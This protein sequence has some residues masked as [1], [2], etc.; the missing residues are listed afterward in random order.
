MMLEDHIA[1]VNSQL[2]Y[3]EGQIERFPPDNPRYRPA[4][5]DMYRRLYERHMGLLKYLEAQRAR[6]IQPSPTPQST[7]TES[8]V[9]PTPESTG[10]DED[11]SDL[12]P[13]LLAQLSGRAKKGSSDPLVQIINDRGGTAALDE[14]LIDLYRRT[15]EIGVRN[16]ISNK[17]YRLTK[18]GF[19]RAIEGKRG[20]YT[21][22]EQESPD[23]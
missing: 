7:P 19:V 17:L 20:V 8:S 12:P 18:Q 10:D 5:I 9:A 21:T 2:D 3:Y 1:L 16:V 23:A 14:I 11:L 6:Q 22:A 4:Q 15:K 13:E